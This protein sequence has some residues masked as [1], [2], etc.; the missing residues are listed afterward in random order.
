VL[1]KELPREVT[2]AAEILAAIAQLDRKHLP[3][4]LAAIAGRMADGEPASAPPPEPDELLDADQVAALLKFRKSYVYELC[5]TKQLPCIRQGKLVR[6]RR[7]AVM[8]YINRHERS[9]TPH[10][11]RL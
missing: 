6:V 3:A 4:L 1:G 10:S 9:L 2:T 8:T 5:R 11:N 7:S